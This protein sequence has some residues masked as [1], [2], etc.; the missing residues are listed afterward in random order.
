[1]P[2]IKLIIFDWDDVFTLGS[3]EGYFKCYHQ[4]LIGVG[5]YLEPKEEKKRI[6]AKWG[7]SHQEELRELLK[8]RPELLNQACSIYKEKLFGNTFIDCLSLVPGAI[9]LLNRLSKNYLLTVATGLNPVIMKERVFPKFK[10]PDVFSQIISTHDIN[11][12]KKHKPSPY[13]ANEILKHHNVLP[14]EALL[15]GDA[16][17]D[18]LMAYS[19]N[20]IPVA[21][22]TGHLSKK[23]AKLL[24]VKYIIDN[25]VQIDKVL[26]ELG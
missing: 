16:E 2:K 17:N 1:M 11:D 20:I 13:I 4:A 5:V 8:E 6:L 3:K 15:V 9:G 10:I 21:V 25:I 18:V 12:P 7:Q 22:L 19:A 14:S 23:E 26:E 24:N